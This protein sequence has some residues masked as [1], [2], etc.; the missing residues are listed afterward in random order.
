M[1]RSLDTETTGVDLWHGAKPFFVTFCDEKDHITYFEWEVDPHTREPRVKR[2]DLTAIQELI[3]DS[4]TLV[5]QNP[6]FDY[7]ALQTVFEGRLR[8][9][10]SKVRDTLL[11]GH[12]INSLEPHNLTDMVSKYL[13]LDI[14]PYEKDLQAA[15][16]EARRYARSHY[17]EWRIAKAGLAEMPSAGGKVWKFDTWLPKTLAKSEGMLTTH[18]YHTALRKYGNIDSTCTLA[19]YKR[20]RALL[21]EKG[22]WKI[23]KHRLKVLPIVVHMEQCGVHLSKHRLQKLYEEYTRESERAGKTCVR[24][25]KK[26]GADLTLPKS[27]VNNS[28]RATIFDHLKLSPLNLS[29]RTGEPSLNQTVL[30]EYGELLKEDDPRL[31]FIQALQAKR[32]RDTAMVYMEAYKRFWLKESGSYLLHPSLNPTGTHTLRWSSS[33]PNE[34][35]I[36]KKEG[37]N[38][39]YCFGP[40]QGRE[41]WSLDA[42][43]IELRI[44][45]YEANETDLVYVFDH[46]EEAPYFG[47]YHLVVADLLHPKL[48]KEYGAAFKKKFSST[49]YQWL[50]NGNFAVIYGCQQRKADITYHVVGAYEKIRRRFPK[51]AA[52]ADYQIRYARERGYVETIP[53]RSLGQQRGYPLYC[54]RGGRTGY[55]NDVSPTLPLNYHVQGTAMQW[56]QNGMIRCYD[57]LNRWNREDSAVQYFMIMQ[58]HDELVFDF[59]KSTMAESLKRIQRIKRAM[60]KGGEDIGVPTTVGVEYHPHNW[61]EGETC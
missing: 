40:A 24:I 29:R 18:P 12:L 27:G 51:I 35:N 57:I 9:E 26:Y 31:K 8:W 50:K 21:R 53:D 32:K 17:P 10:W 7:Q 56:M 47:S 38:L 1:M 46:P 49:W 3:D 42:Q 16:E 13:G 28:L 33:R 44:P 14:Q 11:A 36:S 54:V 61:S 43:N 59:P 39:R 45:A 60:E 55:T 15:S 30:E 41:W 52:L 19:L 4:E 48:F 37:F 22:L 5:L 2:K 20:Q 58:V 6:K 23:Y 34:Q 25:A